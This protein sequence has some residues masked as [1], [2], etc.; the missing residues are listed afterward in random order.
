M[1]FLTQSQK[2]VK[3]AVCGKD[4]LTLA[5]P[6]GDD[7]HFCSMECSERFEEKKG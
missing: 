6:A 1:D 3:C 7:L 2:I 4:F 5:D